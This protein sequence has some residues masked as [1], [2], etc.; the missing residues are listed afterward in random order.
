MHFLEQMVLTAFFF[1]RILC[2]SA[3]GALEHVSEQIILNSLSFRCS[4][5]SLISEVLSFQHLERML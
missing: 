3:G 2:Y 5:R 4:L 1:V